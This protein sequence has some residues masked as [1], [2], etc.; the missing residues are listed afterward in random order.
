MP[1]DYVTIQIQLDPDEEIPNSIIEECEAVMREACQKLEKFGYV[2]AE[3]FKNEQ[4]WTSN[5]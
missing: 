4:K 3:I 2:R 5:R 1:T